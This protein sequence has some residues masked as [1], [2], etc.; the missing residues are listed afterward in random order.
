MFPI[1][2]NSLFGISVLIPTLAS[3]TNKTAADP[4]P[5][6]TEDKKPT[7]P[8]TVPPLSGKNELLL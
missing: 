6:S 8:V 7:L 2:V 4:L 3:E 1:T 5:N